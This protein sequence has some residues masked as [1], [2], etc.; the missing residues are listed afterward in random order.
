MRSSSVYDNV[1]PFQFASQKGSV[2]FKY[3]FPIVPNDVPS[4]AF[5]LIIGN[6]GL[7]KIVWWYFNIFN[8]IETITWFAS[9][10]L[11]SEQVISTQST[12]DVLQ[13]CTLCSLSTVFPLCYVV[14]T[15][16]TSKSNP[17]KLKCP[18]ISRNCWDS[19]DKYS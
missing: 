12:I 13:Y 5:L 15:N 1:R 6:S 14:C 10:A 16:W 8:D 3:I 7:N 17:I 9:N 19:L 4:I 18:E 2:N 11:P